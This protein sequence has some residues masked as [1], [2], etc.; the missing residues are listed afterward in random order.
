MGDVTGKVAIVT[1]SG[2]GIGKAMALTYGGAGAKVVV[3][4]RSRGTVDSVAAEIQAAGGTAIGVT[5]D[6]SQRDQV[7]AMVDEA[8]RA[9]GTVDILVNAAQSFGPADK[10]TT[11][12]SLQ[13][14]EDFDEADWE[15]TYTTGLM[16]SLWGMKAVFPHMKAHGGKIINF[17]S[18]AGLAS[19]PGTAAY[20]MTKEAVR[21]LSRTAAREWGKYGINVNVINPLVMTDALADYGKHNPEL[22][23]ATEARTALGRIG[24]P[25]RVAGPLAIFLGSSESDYITGMTFQLNGGQFITP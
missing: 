18:T 20:N 25:V 2:R 12:A 23:A 19:N 22:L 14:L 16:G 4:S 9:F 6:V 24:D 11:G 8:V 1:G 3:A 13:P 17:S 7:F 5:C 21:S 10:P 15:H